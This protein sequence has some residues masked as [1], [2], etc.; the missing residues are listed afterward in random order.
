M[1]LDNTPLCAPC[2]ECEFEN[3]FTFKQARLRDVLICRGCKRNIRLD[4]RLNECKRAARQFESLM[5]KFT[6]NLSSRGIK[7]TI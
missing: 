7:I 3:D 1:L 2:P 5:S 6:R 4:D